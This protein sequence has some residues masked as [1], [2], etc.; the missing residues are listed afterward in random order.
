M[1]FPKPEVRYADDSYKAY[2]RAQVEKLLLELGYKVVYDDSQELEVIH[3][4]GETE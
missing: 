4:I 3:L 1:L 2:S